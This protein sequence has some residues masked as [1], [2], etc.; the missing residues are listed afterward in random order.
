M[1]PLLALVLLLPACG[2][3]VIQDPSTTSTSSPS[4]TT[5]TSNTSSTDPTTSTSTGSSSSTGPVD[6]TTGA[7]TDPSTSSESS[8]GTSTGTAETSSS[9]DTSSSDDTGPQL[10][11]ECADA[12]DCALFADCCECKGAPVGDDPPLC[13]LRCDQTK[14]DEIA[15]DEAICRLG[16]CIAERL[17]CDASKVVCLAFPPDCPDGTRPGVDGACW[18]GACVPGEICNVV[19][20]CTYCPQDWMCVT[21]VAFGPQGSTC[22][23]IPEG[24]MG[25]P[26]C[27][28]AGDAVCTDD[29]T[30]CSDP[31][32][33]RL[34]CECIN[35]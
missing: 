14:C 11:G 17:D 12:S 2:D 24:C 31:G 5:G 23:P 1:R 33:N 10:P 21:R 18:S 7:P 3:D 35:C 22:E 9:S 30:F 16:Q 4:S 8:G 20:D 26:S 34:D 13:D 25:D 15:V 29:F 19:P 27:A 6:P 32:G 28:C